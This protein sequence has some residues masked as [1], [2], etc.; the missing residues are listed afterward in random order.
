MLTLINRNQGLLTLISVIAWIIF[1][2]TT[3]SADLNQI[4]VNGQQQIIYLDLI[5]DSLK[6]KTRDH[7]QFQKTAEQTNLILTKMS[8]TLIR[9]DATLNSLDKK[10]DN[11]KVIELK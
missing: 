9:L 11:I 1:N 6:E 4:K 8:D 3:A 2:Y 10:I 7:S 5:S